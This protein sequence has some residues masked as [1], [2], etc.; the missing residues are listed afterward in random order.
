MK[1]THSG[2]SATSGPTIAGMGLGGCLSRTGPMR[3][4]GPLNEGIP[5][6][7]RSHSGSCRATARERLW[8]GL[9]VRTGS[10]GPAGRI[11]F[12]TAS[13]AIPSAVGQEPTGGGAWP[14]SQ[15]IRLGVNPAATTLPE[16]IESFIIDSLRAT[17]DLNRTAPLPGVGQIAHRLV[18]HLELLDKFQLPPEPVEPAIRLRPTLRRPLQSSDTY[19][20]GSGFQLRRRSGSGSGNQPSDELFGVR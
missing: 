8:L 13:P 1:L 7:I 19:A 6:C 12:G 5:P 9:P 14:P 10:W 3:S 18:R 17:Y 20:H 15:Y 4:C 2:T 16:P 11:G